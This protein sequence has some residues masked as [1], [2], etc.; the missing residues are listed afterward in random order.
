MVSLSNLDR[1]KKKNVTKK[2]R[3]GGTLR[4]EMK[5]TFSIKISCQKTDENLTYEIRKKT[6]AEAFAY[7]NQQRHRNGG[8]AWRVVEITEGKKP[9]G[10]EKN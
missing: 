1:K 6:F 10:H 4:E 8:W 9:K 7:A 5:R 3:R 2:R